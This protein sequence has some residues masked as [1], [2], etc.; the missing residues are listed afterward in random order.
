MAKLRQTF[1]FIIL[2]IV[3][4]SFQHK[5]I[6][7][8]VIRFEDKQVAL[9]IGHAL[10]FYEDEDNVF[11]FSDILR[12]S[13]QKKF[14]QSQDEVPNFANTTSTIWCKFSVTNPTN[15]ECILQIEKSLI[16]TIEFFKPDT[17]GKYSSRITGALH[18]LAT[19]EIPDN[20]F[21]FSILPPN[22]TDTTTFYIRFKSDESLDL[23]MSIGTNEALFHEHRTEEIIFG[24]FFGILMVMML[25]NLFIFFIIRERA[26]LY[27]VFYILSVLLLN[28]IMISG[29]FFE[30]LWPNF[31]RVNFYI[32]ALTSIVGVFAILFS[33]KFLG[34][35]FNTPKLHKG[36]FFFYLLS[37][38]VIILNFSGDYFISS[39]ACQVETL[40]LSIY[41]IIIG[42]ASLQK[43][44]TIARFYLIAWSLLLMSAI[45]YVLVMNGVLPSTRFSENIIFIGSAIEVILLSFALADRINTF[46]KEKE[47]ADREKL[48]VTQQQNEILERKV[49]ERTHEIAAQNQEIALQNEELVTQQD[50]I[51]VQ[52]NELQIRNKQLED[53]RALIESKN[54]DL[55]N[56]SEGLE[57]EIEKRS[58][59]LIKSNKELIEQNHQL[60]QFA[61]ISAHNLRAPVARIQGLANILDHTGK[62][63]DKEENKFI[64]KKIVESSEELDQVIHDLSRILEV[65]KGSERLEPVDVKER[66]DRVLSIL[67]EQ[68]ETSGTEIVTKLEVTLINSFPQYIESIL[69][70][71]ISNA[72][73]Y[74]DPLKK[75]KI[76]IHAW[77][78]ENNFCLTVEDNGI[79][80][81]LEK[82]KTKI[83]GLY[84]RFHSHVEGKGLGLHLVKSQ[85]ESLGGAIEVKSKPSEGT[86]F[87][88]TLP[89]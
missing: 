54:L 13:I 38:F 73:K 89:R 35:R 23:P 14:I 60:E 63:P 18:P 4:A 70:N 88:I 30:F 42:V 8:T 74:R 22:S 6:A 15:K 36:F 45:I 32:N 66:L 29:L 5:S 65:K 75:S 84:Q 51:Q 76:N 59:D 49:L 58:F 34:T 67:K 53:A 69:Y 28:D 57:K 56:Y 72:I 85:V 27:Y 12:D 52:N 17:K 1:L 47:K 39:I 24:I 71:L 44:S 26:Y 9:P 50:Q 80:F 87:F 7:Q 3:C 68:I 40:L 11:K 78:E 33:S 82:I 46:R 16:H 77:Q 86:K 55:R 48:I 81:D 64:L 83:F 41:L 21:L 43:G 61:F 19:R 79:G 25:Y 2:I 62:T 31:P 20:F 37:A 10:Y